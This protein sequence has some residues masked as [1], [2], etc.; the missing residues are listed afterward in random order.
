MKWNECEPNPNSPWTTES[1]ITFWSST[2]IKKRK[3]SEEQEEAVPCFWLHWCVW[4]CQS[5]PI[6]SKSEQSRSWNENSYLL[7]GFLHLSPFRNVESELHAGM[8]PF[9]P[10]QQSLFSTDTSRASQPQGNISGLISVSPLGTEQREELSIIEKATSRQR[11]SSS[12]DMEMEVGHKGY[13]YIE[14]MSTF[15]AQHEVI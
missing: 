7:V 6:R 13:R 1:T 10:A 4:H 2:L 5:D 3:A 11:K 14:F 9:G 12:G 15:Y 8:K